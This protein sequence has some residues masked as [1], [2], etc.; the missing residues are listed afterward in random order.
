[1]REKERERER[2]AEREKEKERWRT[3][4]YTSFSHICNIC[5]LTGHNRLR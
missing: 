4:M 5:I 3:A 2:E 1:M